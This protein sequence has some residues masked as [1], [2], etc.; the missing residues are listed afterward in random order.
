MPGHLLVQGAILML[1]CG[2]HGGMV[3]DRDAHLIGWDDTGSGPG[4]STYACTTCV[5]DHGLVPLAWTGHRDT[6]PTPPGSA[7]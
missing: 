4:R 5:R 7:A 3:P 1:R 6:A 2:T